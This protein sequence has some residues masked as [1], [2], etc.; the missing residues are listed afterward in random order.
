MTPRA[1]I[2]VVGVGNPMRRDDGLGAAAVRAL[3]GRAGVELV[4]LDGEATRLIDA[5]VG[6]RL[7][8]VV[9][10]AV[11]GADPGTVHEVV[12]GRDEVPGWSAGGSTHAAGVAEAVALAEALD[13]LPDELVILGVEPAD[14]DHG[15][16]LSPAVAAAVPLVVDRIAALRSA[17]ASP[18]SEE[19]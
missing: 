17:H 15:P 13:R 14:L 2:V 19:D 11:T 7:A 4:E 6:R 16:G 1:P 3:A 18:R 10:A 5:W 8:I 12:V 9:D